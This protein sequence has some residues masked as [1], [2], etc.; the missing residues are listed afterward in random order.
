MAESNRVSNLEALG[1]RIN[2]NPDETLQS[3]LNSP[4]AELRTRQQSQNEAPAR[5][6]RIQHLTE[7]LFSAKRQENYLSEKD[8]EEIIYKIQ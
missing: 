1:S 6:V 4:E 2:E 7:R 3:I 8:P 5:T